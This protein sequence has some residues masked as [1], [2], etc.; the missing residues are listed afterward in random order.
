MGVDVFW[1]DELD[2]DDYE[3]A[4]AEKYQERM[5][6]HYG[7]KI[8]KVAELCARSDDLFVVYLTCFRC[9]PDSF[10][11][12]YVKDIMTH[13]DRPFLILQLD[14]LSSDVGYVTRIE[15]G[16]RSF[17]C[18]LREKKEKATPQ[19]VVR[20]RDDRLEKG[21]TVLV[22]YIDVLVSEFWT[23]CFNRA[24]YDAVLLDPS[25]R[26][27]NTGYQYASGGE[28]MPLVSILG[29]AV[30]KV[31]ERRLDP[32]RTF[33]HMPTVCIA[34]NFAQFP[35]LADLV[36]QSAGLDGLKIGLTNTLTPG[37]L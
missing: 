20:A 18:F 5:H 31:K 11:I 15:A 23:K 13:Y 37:K 17:E 29:S 36:F 26:A 25:A 1:Q 16:L 19:A 3:P 21:D 9:S 14:E 35:I 7:K 4:Y 6:W 22:P 10:L 30:E 2:V 32:R 34:C 8:V 33:F 28:C 27:L 12:S 24:G